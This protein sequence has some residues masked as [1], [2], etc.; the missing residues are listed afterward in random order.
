M[1]KIQDMTTLDYILLGVLGI[2]LLLVLRHYLKI[3]SRKRECGKWHTDDMLILDRYEGDDAYRVLKE[4]G[5]SYAILKGWS[6]D[7]LYVDVHD[8]NVYKIKWCEMKENKSAL[9]R[10]NFNEAKKVMGTDPAFD[11]GVDQT[12]RNVGT[13][14]HGISGTVDGKPIE[15]LSEVECEVY[16]KKAVE[17]EDYKVAEQIRKRMEHFR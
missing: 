1:Y 16:L 10:N 8:G 9:W 14:S 3:Q 5:K 4:S 2:V 7:H 13:T 17:T 15:L 11:A 12:E 6:L